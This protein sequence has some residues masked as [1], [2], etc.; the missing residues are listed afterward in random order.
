MR[1]IDRE[2]DKNGKKIIW[3]LPMMAIPEDQ[4]N[5]TR[6]SKNTLEVK[7]LTFG[8]EL[9]ERKGLSFGLSS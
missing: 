5:R 2:M 8:A 4:I 1:S 7:E 3:L 9:E 6:K